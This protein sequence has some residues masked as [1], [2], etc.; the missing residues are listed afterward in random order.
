MYYIYVCVIEYTAVLR[1]CVCRERK[2]T[3]INMW[4]AY[5]TP[6]FPFH[7][8]SPLTPRVVVSYDATVLLLYDHMPYLIAAR[9][10]KKKTERLKSTK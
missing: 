10:K 1:I 2:L 6:P 5:Y 4:V 8:P 3:I 9:N 7:S